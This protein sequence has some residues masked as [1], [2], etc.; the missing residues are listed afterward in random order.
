MVSSGV[1]GPR[2][3]LWGLDETPTA[4]ERGRRHPQASDSEGLVKLGFHGQKPYQLGF[5]RFENGQF[6]GAWPSQRPLGVRL[7]PLSP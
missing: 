4:R 1:P 3:G 6:R 2:K 7:D 5:S